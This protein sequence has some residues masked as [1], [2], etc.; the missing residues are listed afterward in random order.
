MGHQKLITDYCTANWNEGQDQQYKNMD[1]TNMKL[2]GGFMIENLWN[3][4]N[5][6]R[7][8][9]KILSKTM[10]QKPNNYNETM[11]ARGMCS[12]VVGCQCAYYSELQE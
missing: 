12:S 5:S 9:D 4:F 2:I 3:G 7:L 1:M 10:V 8:R 11:N 6:S